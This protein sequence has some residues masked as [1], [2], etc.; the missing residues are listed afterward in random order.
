MDDIV[1]Y[2]IYELIIHLQAKAVTGFPLKYFTIQ[3]RYLNEHDYVVTQNSMSQAYVF[4]ILN[5]VDS[6]TLPLHLPQSTGLG[7]HLNVVHARLVYTCQSTI[8]MYGPAFVKL[9]AFTRTLFG[10]SFGSQSFFLGKEVRPETSLG[11][12]LTGH[13]AQVMTVA[14]VN[15]IGT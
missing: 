5:F 7:P 3:Y 2:T 1:I 4:I 15:V 13:Y 9:A 8:A 12:K 10:S 6:S 14:Y 11:V